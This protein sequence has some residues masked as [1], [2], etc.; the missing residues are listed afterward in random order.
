MRALSTQ[1]SVF[2]ASPSRIRFLT[3]RIMSTLFSA[4]EIR[5]DL[6]SCESKS[7]QLDCSGLPLTTLIKVRSVIRTVKSLY[8]MPA[9]IDS[10]ALIW[11]TSLRKQ[12]ILDLPLAQRSL[13]LLMVYHI[14]KSHRSP[15][16]LPVRSAP[17]SPMIPRNRWISYQRSSGTCILIL[18]TFLLSLVSHPKSE[19]TRVIA[20]V[21]EA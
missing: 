4:S 9:W 8:R 10:L 7:S 20:D 16:L 3:P 13:H 18:L 11:G 17:L 14:T 2:S 1:R 6:G 19:Y 5:Y 21:C 15:L 12:D